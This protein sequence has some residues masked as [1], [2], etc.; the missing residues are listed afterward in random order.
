MSA[1]QKYILFVVLA[2]LIGLCACTKTEQPVSDDLRLCHKGADMPIWVRGN[3]D[4]RK[5]V[6]YLHGG[7]GD[8]AM[9][10]RYYLKTL[11]Q[12]FMVA[13]WDQRIAG[14]AS[15][16]AQPE[17]LTYA[18]FGE[19]TE[20]V[21]QLLRQQ[22]PDAKIFLL[23]HSFGVEL[24]WQF[25]SKP[26][27]QVQIA[28]L[29][30]VNG[31]FSTYRWLYHQ[32]EWIRREAEKQGAQ[33]ALD[34]INAHPVTPATVKTLDWQRQY[35]WMLELG[36][37]PVSITSDRKYVF[38]Y[39]FASPNTALAQFG[40][41]SAYGEYDNTE[42]R[43]FDQTPALTGVT[44]PVLMLWGR[45]DGVV[46]ATLATETFDLLV[47]CPEK[48]IIWFENAWHEPFISENE[49]FLTELT[50]FLNRF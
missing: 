41:A 48:E 38:N 19:D 4:S 32:S 16:N 1:I 44:L 36:G 37:N 28:G 30:T 26:A 45:K 22:Y 18:Q 17:S 13:Y 15:G 7:P 33:A 25:L 49:Q 2:A 39:L 8:C 23:A 24:A 47:N 42:I 21:I 50:T 12:D 40:H 43:L 9:C 5:I 6:L 35:R 14:A 31:T 10:Y 27:N 29:I 46:P 34:W 20:L 3:L 11:E